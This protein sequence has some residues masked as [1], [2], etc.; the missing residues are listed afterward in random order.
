M[1]SRS[2][3]RSSGCGGRTLGVCA[4]ADD[5]EV[6]GATDAAGATE[7]SDEELPHNSRTAD[8]SGSVR[9]PAWN[10][11]R[12]IGSVRDEVLVV[13]DANATVAGVTVLISGKV[14]K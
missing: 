6:A 3:K 7:V 10:S 13:V 12:K 8:D 2:L 4:E 5:T 14:D 9:S 1:P 11:E